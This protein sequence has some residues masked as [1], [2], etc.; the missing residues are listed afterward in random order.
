M[1]KKDDINSIDKVQG[2][3]LDGL[4]DKV[5]E[6]QV[7]VDLMLKKMGV[8]VAQEVVINEGTL[9]IFDL[10]KYFLKPAK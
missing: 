10:P 3:R 6:L 4:D 2:R 1:R 5:R 9:A 7:V 8:E